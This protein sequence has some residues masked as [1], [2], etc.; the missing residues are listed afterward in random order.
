MSDKFKEVRICTA[1][2]YAHCR[3]H[4]VGIASLSNLR[5]YALVPEVLVLF[6]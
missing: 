5:M 2:K 3:T 6:Y 4:A 1:G